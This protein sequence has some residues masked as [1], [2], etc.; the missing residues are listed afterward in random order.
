MRAHNNY[1][2][3]GRMMVA[4]R[5]MYL[6]LQLISAQTI[7]AVEASKLNSHVLVTLV[8]STTLQVIEGETAVLCV[9]V[10]RTSDFFPENYLLPLVLS[11][12][13]AFITAGRPTVLMQ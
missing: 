11:I 2:A 10:Q 8:N 4:R 7:S 5:W 1:I 6:L 12:N 3:V 9:L 13:L